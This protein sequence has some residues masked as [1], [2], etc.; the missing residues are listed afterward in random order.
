MLEFHDDP[1]VNE[2]HGDPTVN[3]SEIVFFLRQGWWSAGK[4]GFLGGGEK[5]TKLREKGGVE[6]I[7]RLQTNLTLSDLFCLN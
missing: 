3:E 6:A 7:V 4:R 5:K 1:T 2:F